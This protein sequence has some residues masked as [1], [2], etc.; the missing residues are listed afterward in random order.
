[1]RL[2]SILIRPGGQAVKT[3]PFHGGNS[4]SIPDG[5]TR[6]KSPLESSGLLLCDKSQQQNGNQ[7]CDSGSQLFVP[8]LGKKPQKYVTAVRKKCVCG[9]GSA[10]LTAE[11]GKKRTK[12]RQMG[13]FKL[14]NVILK[15]NVYENGDIIMK[16]VLSGIAE[17]TQHLFCDFLQKNIKNALTNHEN[18]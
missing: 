8:L 9:S 12:P 4:G 3:P 2:F 18:T 14:Q 7:Q 13:I 16:V 1:M 17:E 5:V 10:R 11:K 6:H 15:K